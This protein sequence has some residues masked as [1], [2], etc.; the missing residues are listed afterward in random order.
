MA[1]SRPQD[2]VS[3]GAGARARL[4]LFLLRHGGQRAAGRR[5]QTAGRGRVSGRVAGDEDRPTDGVTEDSC[6]ATLHIEGDEG[7]GR[8]AGRHSQAEARDRRQRISAARRVTMR[9]PRLEQ[10]VRGGQ[11]GQRRGVGALGHSKCQGGR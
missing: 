4:R 10:A 1:I 8:Q 3:R 5:Q 2:E 6:A 7:E 9:I 11:N